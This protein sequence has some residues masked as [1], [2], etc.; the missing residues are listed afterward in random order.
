MIIIERGRLS[1][2]L[3]STSLSISRHLFEEKV[4]EEKV[5]KKLYTRSF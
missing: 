3:F 4:V 2:I 1:K 5:G